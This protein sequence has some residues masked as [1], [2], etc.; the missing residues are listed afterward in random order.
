MGTENFFKGLKVIDLSTVLAGPSVG[1]F[2]AEMGAEVIK[3]E[4]PDGDITRTWFADGENT[5]EIS[6]Y[7]GAVNH[8]KSSFQIDL[9][10]EREKLFDLLR[11]ADI[12]LSNFKFGDEE[13]FQITDDIIRAIQ[14][15]IIIAKIQGFEIDIQRV[16]YDVV[17]QAETGFM[18]INGEKNSSP[19]KMPVA[20]MDVLAAHQ[21]KEGILCALLHKAKTGKGSTVTCSLEM[22][23]IASL[24][25][26][27]SIYLKSGIVPKASGSLH[28]TICPYGEILQFKDGIHIVLAVGSNRQFSDL[29]QIL[30]LSEL[31][32]TSDFKTNVLRVSNRTQLITFLQSAANQL[33][34]NTI[35]PL[36]H[37]RHVPVGQIKKM[38]E[39]MEQSKKIDAIKKDKITHTPYIKS[40]AFQIRY[41]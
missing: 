12:L 8:N 20:F 2:F 29:C 22:A 23:G 1:S 38:N 14:P 28:P 3:L 30:N 7:F 15:S 32:S 4:S 35:L 27:G 33:N 18:A 41:D 36:L 40:V 34:G 9:K 37:E 16:A 6:A 17:L 39:V 21:L 13:K 19:L 10:T 26:Q 5:L 25:N 24:M 31:P 11:D